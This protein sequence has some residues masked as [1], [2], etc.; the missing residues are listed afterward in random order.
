M[1]RKEEILDQID[2]VPSLPTVVIELWEYLRDPEA[3][4]DMMARIIEYDP[5]L[6]ANVLQLANSPYF[7]WQGAIA[8][9]KDAI[10]RLG[11]RRIFQMVLCMSA[12]P[13][14]RKPIKGYVLEP[15]RFWQH[16]VACAIGAEKFAEQKNLPE[17]GEAFTAGLLHDIGMIVLGTFVEADDA[18]IRNLIQ[19]DKLPFHVAEKVVLGIDHAEV[20]GELLTRWQLPESIAAAARFHHRPADTAATHEQIVDLVHMADAL[21]LEISSGLGD[22]SLHCQLHEESARRLGLTPA[23]A[24]A[25]LADVVEA[26]EAVRELFAPGM[27]STPTAPR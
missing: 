14:V 2:D 12:A 5:G 26:F 20:A 1:S 4:F 6:T 9:V 17:V 13:L 11:S 25:A 21:C 15:S 16:S 23:V 24:K 18:E 27:A 3:D 22:D 8:S 7:R 10:M 19:E